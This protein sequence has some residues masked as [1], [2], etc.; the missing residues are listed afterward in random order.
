MDIKCRKTSCMYNNSYTCCA[1]NVNIGIGTECDSFEADENK[2]AKDF[3][4]NMFEADTENYA[5]SRHIRE[6]KLTC[7]KC[8][9]LFNKEKHCSANGITVIDEGRGQTQCATF[10]ND[11][12]ENE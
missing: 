5:N 9:C 2:K 12:E 3:S 11:L 8:E 6:V 7:D 10:I 4:R 1:R